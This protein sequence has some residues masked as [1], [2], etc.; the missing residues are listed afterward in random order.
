MAAVPTTFG[1]ARIICTWIWGSDGGA[2]VVDLVGYTC[3]NPHNDIFRHDTR[4]IEV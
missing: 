4:D 1:L 2:L 3:D